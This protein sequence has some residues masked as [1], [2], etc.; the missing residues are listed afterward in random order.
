MCK[1]RQTTAGSA[2]V[3]FSY[4]ALFNRPWM[5]GS[6]SW[7]CCHGAQAPANRNLGHGQV[8]SRQ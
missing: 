3:I 5:S 2:G 8:A 4:P 6:S 1:D 7:S